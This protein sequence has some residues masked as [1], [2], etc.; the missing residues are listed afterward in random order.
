VT[1]VAKAGAPTAGLAATARKV[2]PGVL[3]AFTIAAAS[4]FISEHYGAPTML[5][6]LLIGMAFHFLSVEGPCVAGVHLT[7]SRLLK[8]GVALLGVRVTFGDLAS[9][10]PAPAILTPILIAAAIGAGVLFSRLFGRKTRFGV[11][12]G[13]AVAICGASAALAIASVLPKREDG[14]RDTL[15]TVIAVTSFSTVAMILYPILF[16]AFGFDDR[17][18]GWLL[19]AT[20]HDVAQVVGAGYAVSDEAGAV[21]TYVKLPRVAFLP[22]VVIAIALMS[23]R[24]ASESKAPFPW[25]AVGFAALLAVNSFGLIPSA[26]QKVLAAASQWLL[27]AAIAALGMKTSLK[28]MAD[29]GPRHIG[30]VVGSTLTLLAAA[31]IAVALN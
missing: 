17:Q 12:T 2:A 5:F 15:F 31:L 30:V 16:A 20:I 29:L 11:L 28:A 1:A 22:V 19:G 24:G 4:T 27:V 6:A 26:L 25:F 14:E 10:G 7:S 3:M 13:G 9:L 21:A 18:V 8:I 23:R